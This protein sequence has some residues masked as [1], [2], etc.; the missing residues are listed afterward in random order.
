[1]QQDEIEHIFESFFE[2]YRKTEGD[3]TAWSAVWMDMNSVGTLE[4]NMTKCPRGTIFKIFI[5]KK[6]KT[7]IMGWENFFEVMQTV[8]SEHP[9]LYEPDRIFAEM[10]AVL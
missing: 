5:D 7:E 9:G 10:Q 1:M 3:Q 4:L 2:K 6:K 8:A